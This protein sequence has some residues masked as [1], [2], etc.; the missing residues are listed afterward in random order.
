[1]D[2]FLGAPAQLTDE[3]R[4]RDC[5]R[6]TFTC[7][8]CGTENIYDNMFEG[9][10]STLQPSLKN[11][12]HIPCRGSP[13]EHPIQISNKLQL[14]IRRHIRRYYSGWLLCEDQACRNRTRRLPIAFSRSGPICPACLRSTLRPEYSEK[15]LYNQLC[16]YRFIF[17]WEYAF[18]KVLST[19]DRQ[20]LNRESWN[21]D[22][23]VYKMLKDV[24]DNILST[25]G[26][27]E[28]NLAKLFQAFTA[29]K[30]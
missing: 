24:I 22:K 4:Y 3:E 21:K 17:D 8:D 28:V 30:Y 19:E 2:N 7:P 29:L 11:C 23:D 1:M 5:E 14:D 10:G 18:K 16:F 6:F 13:I 26:Y 27:S 15:A 25:S 9:A 12:C 20:K